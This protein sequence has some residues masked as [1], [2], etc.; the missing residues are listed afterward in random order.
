M[1]VSQGQVNSK[2]TATCSDSFTKNRSGRSGVTRIWG[3]MTPPW[4]DWNPRKSENN[5]KPGR[6][7][8]TMNATIVFKTESCRQVKRPWSRAIVQLERMCAR[9]WI[10]PQKLHLSLTL[11]PHL[12]KLSPDGRV[13]IPAFMANLST[14]CGIS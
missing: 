11:F 9:V 2:M 4:G 8:E 10:F 6:I 3:G 13:F 12:F 7:F 14:P 5:D 1:L